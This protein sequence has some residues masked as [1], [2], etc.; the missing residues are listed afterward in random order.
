[1]QMQMQP[2]GGVISSKQASDYLANQLP[3]LAAE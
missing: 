1:M 3:Q 2:L